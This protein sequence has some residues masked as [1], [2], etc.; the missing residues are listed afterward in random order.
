MLSASPAQSTTLEFVPTVTPGTGLPQT[1]FADPLRVGTC[2]SFRK[3]THGAHDLAR[4]AVAALKAVMFYKGGLHG[5]QRVALCKTFDRCNVCAIDACGE[6]Q[7]GIDPLAVEQNGAG[8]ALA[9]I[10][11][12]LGAGQSDM[13]A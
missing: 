9:A 8:T 11:A 7:A 2:V 10:A 3:K 13:F 4:G 6:C 1:A 12:F 5:V